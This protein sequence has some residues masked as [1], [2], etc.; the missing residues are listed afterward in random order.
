MRQRLQQ[1]A[2]KTSCQWARPTQ[3]SLMLCVLCAKSLQSCPTLCD[4]M[5]RRPPGS[6]VHEILQAR[7]LEWVAMPSSRGSSP[8][9]DWTC[10]SY[11]SC[12]NRWVPCHQHFLRSPQWLNTSVLIFWFLVKVISWP[13]KI[14]CST[15]ICLSC[16]FFQCLCCSFLRL[17]YSQ[18]C[19][20]IYPF[21][22]LTKYFKCLCSA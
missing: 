13:G 3:L 21:T 18:F 4:P 8:P 16:S 5:D 15:H 12:I 17:L 7:V 9:R 20:S 14:R 2:R 6:S 1:W 11:V 22:C 10:I 19:L